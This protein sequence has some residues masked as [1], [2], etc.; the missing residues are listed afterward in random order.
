MYRNVI[1]RA[2]RLIASFRV[3]KRRQVAA[4]C[5]RHGAEGT[6]ILLVTTRRT[7]RWTAPKGGLM[8]GKSPAEAAAIEAW[9]EAGVIGAVESTPIGEYAYQKYRG[10]TSWEPIAVDVFPQEVE[11]IEAKYPEENQRLRQWFAQEKAAEMVDEPAMK[12]LI[13]T[14]RPHQ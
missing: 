4:L 7:G 10:P 11:A 12:A 9:E 2:A 14:F 13:R 6:E 5:W 1:S 8:N 3:P